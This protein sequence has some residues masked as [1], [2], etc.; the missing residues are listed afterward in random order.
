M[1]I[2][3]LLKVISFCILVPLAIYAKP[4]V[5][6]SLGSGDSVAVVD[7]DTDTVTTSYSG[8]KNPH[9]LVATPDGEFLVAGSLYE[10]RSYKLKGDNLNS[11]LFL[12]HPVH[13]HVM[14]T[15]PVEGF[16]H[17]QAITPN[18]RYVISTHPTRNHV[19]IL[20]IED[21]KLLKT[22]N[23]DKGPNYAVVTS[24]G[25][26]AY[27]SNTGSGTIQEIRVSDWKITRTINA[28]P[29][30]EHIILSKNDK[31][32]YVSNGR[33]GMI[34]IIP[35]DNP[36]KRN[37]YKIGKNLHGLDIGDDGQRLFISSKAE[38]KLFSFD[39]TNFEKKE[40]KLSPAPYHLNTIT[41]TGKL[42]VSSAKEPLIWVI[43]QKSLK[44][45]KTFNLPSGEGHQMA[46]VQ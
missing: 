31:T 12:I 43:D 26:Y 16:S 36:S 24:N 7:A 5:Y 39:L 22:I 18:G 19:S 11:N 38:G 15:I 29:S 3:K 6:I 20:D 17:H 32:L 14:Q 9:G 33:K 23:T 25:K 21:S 8:L 35:L 4:T 1:K 28:G 10:S 40:L 13:N 45:I 37:E 41:N 27:V 34:S 46:I 30:P 44:I 2:N 42:Y